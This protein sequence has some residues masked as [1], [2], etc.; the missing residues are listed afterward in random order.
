[1]PN[2]S[3]VSTAPGFS[4]GFSA[5]PDDTIFGERAFTPI[6]GPILPLVAVDG[7]IGAGRDRQ[8]PASALIANADQSPGPTVSSRMAALRNTDI[9]LQSFSIG[10]YRMI[11]S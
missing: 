2:N 8:K 3:P 9:L 10:F 7:G 6:A 11:T 4:A 1:M 5:R